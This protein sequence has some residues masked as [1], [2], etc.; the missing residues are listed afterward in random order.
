MLFENNRILIFGGG[1]NDFENNFF[2]FLEI[3]TKNGCISS[4]TNNNVP[5]NELIL[6]KKLQKELKNRFK[7]PKL[8]K[9]GFL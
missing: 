3:N 5:E 9:Y 1:N 6:A 4:L 8:H 7:D 2:E